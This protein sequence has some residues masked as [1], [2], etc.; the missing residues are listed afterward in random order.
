MNATD[1]DSDALIRYSLKNPPHGFTI[2]EETGVLYANLSKIHKPLK[3]DIQLTVIASDSGMPPLSSTATVRIH[4]NSKSH[5]K[6]HYLQH[7]YRTTINENTPRGT[8]VTK[9]LSVDSVAELSELNGIFFEIITGDDEG[10]FEV[11]YPESYLI[12]T[13]ALDRERND[14]YHLRIQ[15][16][17]VGVQS[18]LVHKEDN[19]SIINVFVAVEDANDERPVFQSNKYEVELS[20]SVPL[21]YSITT[22]VAVDND[23]PNT[24]NSEVVYDITSGNDLGMFSID[25]VTGVLCVNKPLD[26]DTGTQHYNLIIRACDSALVPHCSLQ[27]MS[28]SLKDTVRDILLRILLIF[29]HSHCLFSEFIRANIP[30]S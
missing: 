13:K 24:P 12:L 6:P 17:E 28:I 30:R 23:Q 29:T 10:V 2:G 18:N 15:M 7:Q 1:A 25:L 16:M 9:L 11:T 19:S 26:Y 21:K 4:I 14:Y 8:I 27:T 22:I 20:E 3:S 5:I